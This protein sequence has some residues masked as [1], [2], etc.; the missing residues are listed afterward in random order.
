MTK[1]GLLFCRYRQ[2]RARRAA[3]RGETAAKLWGAAAALLTST[4]RGAL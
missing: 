4:T 2:N 3:A 1:H